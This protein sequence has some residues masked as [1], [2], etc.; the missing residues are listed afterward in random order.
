MTLGVIAV[1]LAATPWKS[2]IAWNPAF[3]LGVMT[4]HPHFRNEPDDLQSIVAQFNHLGTAYVSMIDRGVFAGQTMNLRANSSSAEIG[5]V[6]LHLTGPQSASRTD[7]TAPYTLFE[8]FAG[9]A[10]PAGTYE[11][12]ATAYPEEDGAGTPGTTQRASFTL[13]ADSTAPSVSVQCGAGDLSVS[14]DRV[15]P[16]RIEFSEP[17]WGFSAD[18]PEDIVF[19]NAGPPSFPYITM[20][21]NTFRP[22]R[23]GDSPWNYGVAVEPDPAGGVTTVK[24]P[25]GVATNDSGNANTASETLHIARNRKVSIA[26]ASARE[27]SGATI[28]F[29]VTLDTRNDCETAMVEW[30][31]V[32]G[33]ATAGEDYT[34]AGGVLTFGPGDTTRTISVA[35]LDDNDEESDETFTVQLSNP[36]G[37]QLAGPATSAAITKSLTTRAKTTRTK[38]TGAMATGTITNDDSERTSQQQ[39]TGDTEPPSV[40]VTTTATEP[41]ASGE[42]FFIQVMFSEPVSGFEMTELD[43]SHGSVRSMSSNSDGTL[44][45]VTIR[46]ATAFTG[47]VAI[48]VPAG[49]ASDSAGNTNIASEVLEI[50]SVVES[51]WH[52]VPGGPSVTMRCG[53]PGRRVDSASRFDFGVAI[54]FSEPVDGF[55]YGDLE[56]TRDSAGRPHG[57]W[58]TLM[59]NSLRMDS[60]YELG[61]GG[62][63]GESALWTLR[64][65]AGVAT[66]RDGNPNSAS[67][68]M[69]LGTNRTVSVADAGAT[70]GA[71]EKAD[72]TVELSAVDDCATVR[73]DWTTA[74]G[75]ATAG[76]DYT[77]ASGTLTFGPGETSKTV[78]VEL[79]D[80]AESDDGETFKLQLSNPVGG[81][82]DDAEATGTI[83]ESQQQVAAD[84]DPPTVTVTSDATAP[85]SKEFDIKVTFS[86]PTSGFQKSELEVT[87]A[88][89]LRMASSSDGTEHTVTIAPNADATGEITIA[90]P[91][92]VATD[93]AGNF[94]TA[95]APFEIAIAGLPDV[96]I[97]PPSSTATGGK[98]TKSDE[99]AKSDPAVT[100][101]QDVVFTLTRTG[102]TTDALTVNVSVSETGSMV[103]G[104][105]PATVTFQ[106]DVA[107]ATLTVATHDDSVV[108]ASS[109]I[110][111]SIAAGNGYSL[112]AEATSASSA[113]YDN[114]TAMF[115]VSASPEEIDEG[116]TSTVTVAVSNAVTFAADQTITLAFGDGTAT[117]GTDFTVS[118]ETLTLAAG[119]SSVTATVTAVDDTDAEEA[120]TVVVAASHAGDGIGSA[121]VS[122][123]ASDGVIASFH[124]APSSHD[125]LTKFQFELRFSEQVRLGYKTVRDS[126]LTIEGGRVSSARRI[127]RTGDERNRRWLIR[128]VP[129]TDGD[130]TITLPATAE[131]TA[132][133]AVCTSEGK[134]LVTALKEL[135]SGPSSVALPEVSIAGPSGAVTEGE[136]AEFRLTRT[137][138][139]ADALTVVVSVSESGS[140]LD[141]DPPSE[142]VFSANAA[143]ATLTVN[144]EDDAEDESDGTVTATIDAG[145]GYRI[146]TDG[147]SAT[148]SVSDNDE[149]PSQAPAITSKGPFT[150]DEGATAV[151]TLTASDSAAE[152]LAW[153]IP[154]GADGGPDAGAFTLSATGVLAF[155]EAKD[156][157]APDD[158]DTD[159]TY[160]VTVAVTNGENTTTA[161]LAV[162]LANVNEAPAANAGSDIAGVA[163]GSTATLDGS[164][165][166]DPDAGDTLTYAWAQS[167]S[168]GHAVTLSNA[169]AAKPTFT[170]PTG[171]TAAAT[172]RFTLT[173]TDAAGLSGEDTV[174][175]IVTPLPTVSFSA[176]SGTASGDQQLKSVQQAKPGPAVTEGQDVVFTLTRTGA[177]TAALTV[178]VSVTESGSMVE[179][180]P[181][182]TVTFAARSA[183]STLTVTTDDDD[184]DEPDST[185]T[186]TIGAGSEYRTEAASSSGSKLVADNDEPTAPAPVVTSR[187][188]FTVDE[189]ETTVGTLAAS[190]GDSSAGDFSWSIPAGEAGG[191]DAGKFALSA[192]GVLAFEEAKDFEAPDDA[193][194]DGTYEV[195]VAVSVGENTT[196]AALEVTLADVNEA[197]EA[198]AGSDVAGVAEGATVTL[199]GSG[200]SDPD[201]D[202][203]LSYAWTQSDSSG[204]TVTLSDAAAVNPTFTAPTGLAAD[205]VLSF[206]LEVTDA[207]G[208]ASEDTVDVTVSARTVVSIAPAASPVTEGGAATFVVRRTGDTA[209]PL[210]VAV[211]VDEAGAVVDGTPASSVTIGAGAAQARLSVS[212][213][214]DGTDEADGSVTASVTSGGGYRVDP[215][216][217]SARVDVLDNDDATGPASEAVWSTTLEW[218]DMGGGWLIAYEAN[219]SAPTWT[220][221]GDE[222]GIWYMAYGQSSGE[223]WL[224]LSSEMPRGGIPD[225]GELA[226]QL[227]DVTVAPAGVV[228]AFA[229]GDTA[230]ARGVEQSWAVGDRVAVRLSRAVEAGE[231]ADTGPGISVADAEVR[232]AEGAVLS[233]PVRLQEAQTSAVSV[234]YRTSDGTARAGMDYV[235]V[236]GAVRFEPGETA[237]TVAVPVLNDAHDEGSETLTLTLSH[238]FGARLSD[239]Q[240]TGTIVNTDPMPQAWISRFG[241]TVGSQVVEAVTARFD[242]GVGSHVTLGGVRLGGSGFVPDE[243]AMGR[244]DWRR[245]AEWD[246]E[247]RRGDGLREMTRRELLLGSSFH[248]TSGEREGAGP[249]WAAWG[250]V[251]TDGF[252]SDVDDVRVDGDVTT[253]L[254]GFDAQW[255]RTLAGVLLS[256]SKGEGSYALSGDAGND[257]GE[258]E[259]TL[260]GVYPYARFAM[261]ERVSAWGLAGMGS[262]ELTLRQ[263]GQTPIETDLAMTMG[264][265]GIK[266]AVLDGSGPSGVGLNVK[267]DAMWVRTESDRTAGLES[268]EGDVTRLRLVLEG[269]RAFEVGEGATFTPT[270]QVGLRHDG[271]D[272]ETGTGFEVGAGI[273]YTA[274]PLSIEGAVHALVAHEESGYEEWGA[275]GA[276]RVAPGASGRGLSLTLAPA[277]GNAAG[278]AERLWSAR[279]AVTFTEGEDLE[280][281]GRLDAELGYGMGL[282]RYSG[283]LTPYVGLSLADGAARTYRA[284]ARW[285]VA[286]EA[287]VSLEGT[288]DAGRNDADSA[289]G[290][291]LRAAVRF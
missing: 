249:A 82:L 228:S 211:S 117:K 55:V 134:R 38:S 202:D 146:A 259:S 190:A 20:W 13:V 48:R 153:S 108:E 207:D 291:V 136:D 25:A 168:S 236:S 6:R 141:G 288:R 245:L 287:T 9:S 220:E 230:I 21:I 65:P 33:T 137:G 142:V 131:C 204:H 110:T 12:S 227:G 144:T 39:A 252:E 125:G 68:T 46:P 15:I 145:T 26:D 29:F 69:R 7:N 147:A 250:Q 284:G 96:S 116:E 2:A 60:W 238:P 241:R 138:V 243:S 104:A 194:A 281:G 37:V 233:F 231:P 157:E 128:V 260:T 258:V 229:R 61:V 283:V 173:V 180:T 156:F 124:D 31:T 30:T 152:D 263:E 268:A 166:S 58:G 40:T 172:L 107:T 11:I 79:L 234:R 217:R 154:A 160:E 66:D 189:G 57:A 103:D 240:A 44:H 18:D 22:G 130:L 62:G 286:P 70:E 111:A 266:G 120:E 214:D 155:K 97:A 80:D 186:A 264:A 113:V 139:T 121:S 242:G 76:E 24:V 197:P 278:G 43:V 187:G 215:S 208:L 85:V 114:D 176:P 81:T 127:Q 27:R 165:S 255:D 261:S 56:L 235:A 265:V 118:A 274:G 219:F 174:D 179:G 181:P 282:A 150:V 59:F 170:A 171:L 140:M 95:S 280:A 275:S 200:S 203:T 159:G 267:S 94:N 251:A 256:Q 177:T 45:V 226:L 88:S 270:G 224:K 84:T 123:A 90:V 237:K 92:G 169:A 162:S 279:D 183:T 16:V 126:V 17:V 185:V 28:D 109:T 10:L 216:S 221:S 36:Q 83:N 35:L 52:S 184:E 151:A 75:T 87:N 3:E 77:A 272:A 73:V 273:R 8:D 133:G 34:A 201:A 167:D 218:T 78:S 158:S 188:P 244:E 199:D 247:A 223:L 149:A 239:A 100:E 232:E 213:D 119:A 72:F 63:Y 246:D 248:L 209:Q 112:D 178:N 212:T 71:R 276:I 182:A 54:A 23:L 175:V 195:T 210:T 93:G 49:V 222:F 91:T 148:A 89:A 98:A 206:T 205:T 192:E 164:A 290:I 102:I 53:H 5:S 289:S 50:W 257:R 115:S 193:G 99:Q 161:A 143:T 269:E 132:T 262:G 163:A 253:G 271:G 32:D 1:I 41:L 122:I 254:V 19:T 47:E 225:P 101:G 285:Q 14:S 129:D 106:A 191:T 64:V 105:P 51:P 277:W 74:D 67:E 135:V 4:V 196:T 42:D 86:E 198:D